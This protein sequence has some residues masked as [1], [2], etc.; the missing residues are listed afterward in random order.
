M[1]LPVCVIVC[2]CVNCEFVC[3]WFGDSSFQRA[4]SVV[5]P[6]NPLLSLQG[7]GQFC[8]IIHSSEKDLGGV[9]MSDSQGRGTLVRAQDDSTSSESQ[10]PCPGGVGPWLHL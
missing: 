4:C 3:L 10:A 7:L 2:M 8:P 1:L 6:S 5:L 9:F